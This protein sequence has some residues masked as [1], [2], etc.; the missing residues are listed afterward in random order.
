MATAR[1]RRHSQLREIIAYAIACLVVIQGVALLASPCWGQFKSAVPLSV[2]AASPAAQICDG[3]TPSQGQNGHADCC[4]CIL[5]AATASQDG[6]VRI[7]AILP[8]FYDHLTVGAKGSVVRYFVDDP[9]P[10][11]LGWESSW[12]SRAPPHFS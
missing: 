10:R 5:C 4:F 12:S 11:V 1:D 6:S 9:E 7:L 3:K 8:D 2:A